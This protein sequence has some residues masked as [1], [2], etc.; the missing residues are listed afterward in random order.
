MEWVLKRASKSAVDVTQETIVRLRGLPFQISKEEIIQFF[1][2]T[3]DFAI[4][5]CENKF[6]KYLYLLYI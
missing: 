3:F 2:G 4:F 5:C 1:E 6:M